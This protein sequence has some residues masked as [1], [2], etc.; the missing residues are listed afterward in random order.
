MSEAEP[1]REFVVEALADA[2][3]EV[4]DEG[5][6]LWV[7]SPE[8]VRQ[9]F[10]VP[11]TLALTFDP[12]RVGE[13]GAELVAPGSFLLERI[14][15]SAM[16]RGRW[17]E[18]ALAAVPADWIA[19]SLSRAGF[20][21]ERVGAVRETQEGSHLVFTFRVTLASDEKRESFHAIVVPA[22]CAAGWEVPAA[23][24][25]IPLAATAAHG[26]PAGLGPAYEAAAR[27]LQEAVQPAV[28]AFRRNALSALEEE[29]RRIFAYFDGTVREVRAAASSG[30]E[31]VVRAVEAERDR[32]LTE[33]LERF[34]PHASAVLSGVRR[35]IAPEATVRLRLPG[36]RPREIDVNV[37]ALTRAVRGPACDCCH[38]PAGPR[39][40][41]SSGE[42][43]CGACAATAAGSVPPRARPRSDTPRPR[44][45]A[46]T[47]GARSPRGSTARSR[48][49]SPTH[50]GR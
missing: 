18:G 12:D 32:R 3:A 34:E 47:G 44:R 29:V 45:R 11:E 27:A 35:V 4:K 16:R 49:A 50:R 10:E 37:D 17:E 24:A 7:R 48:S 41:R 19:D 15:Q 23:L 22:G 21:T 28:E 13:F 36:S 33:A 46:S 43:L 38:D 1:L 5:G 25:D 9:A 39:S 26:P 40:L 31:D 2:G 30:A 42:I 20:P 6:I 8:S 14:L